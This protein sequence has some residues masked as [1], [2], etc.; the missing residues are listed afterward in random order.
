MFAP[1]PERGGVILTQIGAGI[2][3]NKNGPE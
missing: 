1:K 3:E 2:L